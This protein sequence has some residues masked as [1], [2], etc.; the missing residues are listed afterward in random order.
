MHY[1]VGLGES[2]ATV[3]AEHFLRGLQSFPI[4]LAAVNTEE[5]R[6][7]LL[8][9]WWELLYKVVEVLDDLLHRLVIEGQRVG[10]VIKSPR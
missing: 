5:E 3:L 9:R 8:H 10:E 4:V 2:I 7:G 1:R 6:Q